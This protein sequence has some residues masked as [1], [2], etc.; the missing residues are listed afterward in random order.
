MYIKC[1]KNKKSFIKILKAKVENNPDM[2][3]SDLIRN[4]KYI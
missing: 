3:I 4:F 1:S 2:I